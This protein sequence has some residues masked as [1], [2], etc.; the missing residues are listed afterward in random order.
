M[1]T[2]VEL[3]P[4]QVRAAPVPDTW[5]PETRTVTV[6][7][8]TGAEARQYSWNIGS[9]L[10]SLEVTE[11]ACDLSRLNAG[12]SVL[13]DHRSWSV[14][15]VIGVVERA[16]IESGQAYAEIRFSDRE[17]VAGFVRDIAA[18]VLRHFSVGYSVETYRDDTQPDDDIKRF[19]AIAWQPF[20][21]SVVPVPAESG[22]GT[23]SAAPSGTHRARVIDGTMTKFGRGV[24]DPNV[25]TTNVDGAGGSEGAAGASSEPTAARAAAPAAPPAP[26]EPAVPAAGQRGTTTLEDPAVIAARARDAERARVREIAEHGR[27]LGLPQEA[28]ERLQDTGRPLGELSQDVAREYQAVRAAADPGEIRGH[29][30]VGEEERTKTREAATCALHERMRP[31]SEAARNGAEHAGEYRGRTLLDVVRLLEARDGRDGLRM[32]RDELVKR[33]FHSTSDFPILLE[34]AGRRT[35]REA[36][37]LAPSTWR[38]WCREADLMDFRPHD[39]ARFGDAPAL[40][41]IP[42]GGDVKFGTIGESKEEVKLRSFGKGVGLDRRALI[43]DDLGA[44]SRLIQSQGQRVEDLV[45]NLAYEELV[46][47]RVGGSG[48]Y[49]AANKNQAGVAL[50]VAGLG[51]LEKL[52]LDQKS[53]GGIPLALMPRF[54]I[55]PTALKMAADQLTAEINPTQATEVNPYR[56]VLTP[57]VEPRLASATEFYLAADPAMID[58]VEIGWL[59]GNRG[60][61]FAS[62]EVMEN[63]GIKFAVF[64]DV[65]AKAID[66]RGLA[67]S[68]GA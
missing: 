52:M 46:G 18:G 25:G 51:E 20:E 50:T 66:F 6:M 55:V 16:W 22:A 28:V 68:T 57:I 49:V 34:E 23:R 39:R 44:F 60:P 67:K 35:L 17:D 33:A 3:P 7:W 11:E 61:Q 8:S 10:E 36:Y 54:L 27:S 15:A 2:T 58:T 24:P 30:Q 41:E 26:A 4:L 53:T 14:N 63:R 38:A 64:A 32:S 31:A 42:N 9:Y 21:L 13:L 59:E 48:L 40:E 5:D 19:T 47:G 62:D 43:N 45:S 56:G 65:T 29:I 1:T 37:E 12:A